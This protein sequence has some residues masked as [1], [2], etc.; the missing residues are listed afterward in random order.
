MDNLVIL[1]GGLDSTTLLYL[2]NSKVPN[3]TGAIT[4][5]YGQRHKK[6]IQSAI[7]TCSKLDLP[8]K[9]V[10]LETLGELAPSSLTR[11]EI[12]VPEGHYQD[13]NMR[14]TI[15][16][17]RNMV[18]LSL[19][20]AYAIGSHYKKVFMGVH[21]GDHAIYPDCRPEFVQAMRVAAALCDWKP[22]L[23]EAPFLNLDKAQIVKIGTGLGVDYSLT[24]TCYSGR[25]K[26][27]SKC[28]SCT[29]R[30]EAFSR[31]GLVDPLEYEE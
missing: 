30:Q 22:I 10:S 24:W 13:D 27:C 28:G 5:N 19:A 26:S 23:V 8:V 20:I 25:E 3:Q 18:L 29:E 7:Q 11:Q 12:E 31:N 9:V 15:V 17:N 16:G 2:V 21:S 4:F 1:S 6:E 14:L